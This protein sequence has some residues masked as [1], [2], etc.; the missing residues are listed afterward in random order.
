MMNGLADRFG[1]A[2]GRA[3]ARRFRQFRRQ[4]AWGRRHPAYRKTRLGRTGLRDRLSGALAREGAAGTPFLLVPVLLAV[5]ASAYF[6][7]P[8]EPDRAVLP[9]A[10]AMLG[11]LAWLGRDRP[12]LRMAML[13]CLSVVAGWGVAS[14]HAARL[15]T[16]MLGERVSTHL[17]GRILRIEPTRTGK[18]RLTLS[19]RSTTGPELQ[20]PPR[21]VRIVAASLPEG[22]MPGSLLSGRARLFPI[23]GPVRP[24]GYDHAFHAFH[25]GIGASGYFLGPPQIFADQHMGTA[26]EWMVT[27]IERVRHALTERIRARL[28]GQE[29]EL[30]SALITGVQSAIDEETNHVLRATGLA[31]ILSISGLHMALV[32]GLV[33]GI[34]RLAGAL[35]PRF[36]SAFPVRKLAAATALAAL[37]LYLFISGAAVATLR[38]A[39]MLGV[40]LGAVLCDRLSLTMRNLAIAGLV[41]L[42][43]HPHEVLNPGFQMSFAATAALI[44]VYRAWSDWKADRAEGDRASGLARDS[45][46]VRLVMGAVHAAFLLALTSLVAGVATGI[47]GI[48]HFHRAAPLGVF[49]NLA[50]MPVVSLAVMPL[51]M[52]S[53]ILIPLGLDWLSFMALGKAIALVVAIAAWFAERTPFD[54]VG[55]IPASSL[56]LASASLI[57]AT[58]LTTRLR[59]FA[60]PLCLG[61]IWAIQARSMPDVLVSEDAALVAVRSGEALAIHPARGNGFTLRVWQDATA[62]TALAL[63]GPDEQGLPSFHCDD[64]LCSLRMKDGTVIVHAGSTSTARRACG[65]ASVI[66]INDPGAP[67][68]ALCGEDSLGPA[69]P[70]VVLSARLLARRGAAE[71]RFGRQGRARVRFAI[72]MPWKPWHRHRGWSRTARGLPAPRAR[73]VEK[74]AGT[75]EE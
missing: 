49:A 18:S 3:L 24:G 54:A 19:V 20:A 31:H 47:Y 11:L 63:P 38:S 25:A 32:A 65:L 50:A 74:A 2:A 73:P 68:A 61:A 36:A 72:A 4:H 59:F 60:I 15:D 40:M 64:D 70:P 51:A 48:W 69:G 75:E 58:L 53:V 16:P 1:G 33:M 56:L 6:L 71:I 42:A 14:F 41:I 66:V 12:L 62:A 67:H 37:L 29:G 52:L 46:I 57:V 26:T 34:I 5:G 10:S 27:K 8:L 39:I 30:A 17:T 35:F 43:V 13:A 44:V 45:V 23:Q 55:A 28:P 9:P 22:A 7:L 21:K